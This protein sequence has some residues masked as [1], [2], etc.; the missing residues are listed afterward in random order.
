MTLG[1]IFGF[2]NT[3]FV[4]HGQLFAF[5]IIFNSS[6]WI[7]RTKDMQVSYLT[8]WFTFIILFCWYQIICSKIKP[9]AK[10]FFPSYTD[11]FFYR[12]IKFHY[13]QITI[14]WV[15][16]Y[17]RYISQMNWLI[18]N[19]SIKFFRFSHLIALFLEL[20]DSS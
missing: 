15:K 9:N 3:C 11:K 20:F 10:W 13:K 19:G 5:T 14:Y 8:W 7:C 16:F 2:G 18:S 12:V 1:I 17:K 6:S 4:K